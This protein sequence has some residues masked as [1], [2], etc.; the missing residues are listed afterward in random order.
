MLQPFVINPQIK[1][2]FKDNFKQYEKKHDRNRSP[3]WNTSAKLSGHTGVQMNQLLLEK[4]ELCC[5]TPVPI[6]YWW[7]QLDFVFEKSLSFG[8]KLVY[9]IYCTLPVW[10]KRLFSMKRLWRIDRSRHLF[11]FIINRNYKS[12]KGCVRYVMSVLNDWSINYIMEIC[13]FA[14]QWLVEIIS[15]QTKPR[16]STKNINFIANRPCQYAFQTQCFIIN[17]KICAEYRDMV[18]KAKAGSSGT[19]AEGDR[20]NP[21]CTSLTTRSWV[22]GPNIMHIS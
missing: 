14:A 9:I 1:N 8:H 6:N 17:I 15:W 19:W 11:V 22:P 16:Y 2:I 13:H 7:R 12:A 5:R 3:Q 4:I 18:P 20:P 10:Q 21:K